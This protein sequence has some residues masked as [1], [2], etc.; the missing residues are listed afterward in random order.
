MKHSISAYLALILFLGLSMSLYQQCGQ[1]LN[2]SEYIQSPQSMETAQTEEYIPTDPNVESTDVRPDVK[3]WIKEQYSHDYKREKTIL[4]LASAYQQVLSQPD[5]PDRTNELM[6]KALACY[7][8]VFGVSKVD[9]LRHDQVL[10]SKVFN[11]AQR[12][13]AYFNWDKK[14]AGSILTPPSIEKWEG[15]CDS[16]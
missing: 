6:L 1:G 12:T 15:Y 2:F 11:T 3:S 4:L 9:G 13:E 7:H 10:L 8:L 5:N 14:I 16:P